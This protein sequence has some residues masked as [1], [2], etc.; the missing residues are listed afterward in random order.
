MSRFRALSR[1]AALAAAAAL[2][3]CPLPQPLPAYPAT[4][5][6]APPRIL[7]D[8]VMPNATVIRVST[9]CAPVPPATAA[10]PIFTLSAQ[11][12][13]DTTTELVEARWFVD[14]D[15]T[16]S[17]RGSLIVQN[18][19]VEAP[20]SGDPR[21]RAL[22]VY[23]FHPYV[24]FSPSQPVAGDVH[25]VE[26]VVSNGFDPAGPNALPLPN[27]SPALNFETQYYRWVFQYVASGGS[28]GFP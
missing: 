17:S 11:V 25:V 14:Y 2:V 24:F 16:A 18:D 1:A 7:M 20:T 9:G 26:L 5:A 23:A 28:C 21:V 3:G 8:A 10:D 19:S 15:A 27:R 13:D 6:I 4:G 12:H 22:P